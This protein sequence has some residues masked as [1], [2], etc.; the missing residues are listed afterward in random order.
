MPSR[1]SVGMSL[2]IYYASEL[3]TTIELDKLHH[4]RPVGEYK[5]KVPSS[6]PTAQ[7]V[8]EAAKMTP[9]EGR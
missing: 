2:S 3:Q 6:I 7:K 5:F 9:G 4:L 8:P 1:V